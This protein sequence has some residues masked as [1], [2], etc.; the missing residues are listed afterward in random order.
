M[1]NITKTLMIVGVMTLLISSC[2]PAQNIEINESVEVT[3]PTESHDE[4]LAESEDD[5]SNWWVDAVFYEIFVR[6]FKDSDGDGIGDFQGIIQQLDYLNDGDPETHDDLGVTG[7]WLMPINPSPSYHGYDVTNYFDVNRDYGTLDDLKQL[8][9]EAHARGIHV[10]MDLV[11]NHTSNRHPWFIESINPDSGFHDWYVWAEKNP[12]TPGPWGQ[13]AWYKESNDLYYYAIF[14]SGMPDLN[15]EN[16]QVNTMIFN[17]SRFWLEK[18]GMDGFR[19]DAARYL[20][21]DGASQQDTKET[22]AWFK[23]W[24]SIV[25]ESDPSAFTVGEVWTNVQAQARYGGGT[26]FDSLFMFDT[27]EAILNGIYAPSPKRIMGAYQDAIYYFP[28]QEFSTFLSNHDQQRVLSFYKGDIEKAKMAAFIYLT[29]PGI[30]FI[31]YG[32]EIGMTGNKPDENLRTPMQWTGE[33]LAGFSSATN[34]R[35][36]NSDYKKKN[37]F[38]QNSDPESLLSLYRDLITLRNTYSAIRTGEYIPL[39]SSCKFIYPIL[40]VE[41]ESAILTI[42]NIGNNSEENCTLSLVE[43]PLIGTYYL[44]TIFGEGEYLPMAFTGSG[45]L[46]LYQIKSPIESGEMLILSLIQN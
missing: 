39:E 41:D 35:P 18:I 28:D 26:G 4:I 40:R 13:N 34:W 12:S 17:I 11:I 9:E 45:S 21:A 2:Q 3:I 1:K 8:I 31:Y 43:S 5:S 38:L 36:I 7:I 24:R 16:A 33:P 44:E 37:V 25:K 42:V 15:Y 32:E 22:I 29:G 46:D 19:V 14:W 27:S 20:F 23:T 6:S 30:P 10:I